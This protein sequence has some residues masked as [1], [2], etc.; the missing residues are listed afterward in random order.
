MSNPTQKVCGVC[1]SEDVVRDGWGVWDFENQCWELGDLFD[2]SFCR[3]CDGQCFIVDKEVTLGT[4]E[5]DPG[6]D[7]SRRAGDVEMH[8]R[9]GRVR[10]REHNIRRPQVSTELGPSESD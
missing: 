2:Y 9:L 10:D 4:D 8:D 6:S 5:I 3:K 7:D 1:G